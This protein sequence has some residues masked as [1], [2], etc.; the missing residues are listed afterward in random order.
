M[1]RSLFKITNIVINSI[2][3]L[4]TVRHCYILFVHKEGL[5]ED[6]Y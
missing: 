4:T 6:Y 1:Q 5:D 3:Q 2:K